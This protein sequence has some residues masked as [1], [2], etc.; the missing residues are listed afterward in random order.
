MLTIKNLINELTVTLQ[1]LYDPRE[2]AAIASWYVCAKLGMERYELA[3]RGNEILD[4]SLM[5]EVRRNMERL[6]EGC[7]VQYVLGE[8][9]FYGL[10]FTVSPAVL[11]PR[12][13]TEELV[14]MVVQRYAGTAPRI[15]DVGTGSGCIAVSLAKSLK[16]A[17]VFATDISSEALTVAR[18]N[19]ERNGVGVTFVCH[20]MFDIENLPFAEEKFDVLV[21]NPPYIPASDRAAMHRNVVD[22]EPA[23][24]LFVPDE[25][26]LWCYKALASLARRVLAP[27]GT[28]WVETYHDYHEEMIDLFARHGFS[29][30]RSLLD[31]NG[32]PR[33]LTAS[34]TIDR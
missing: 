27:G 6:A 31:L 26:K 7:P 5:Q 17:K 34:L 22:Y 28:L 29:D 18:G 1:P 19:A 10:S 32:R 4:E 3:L 2:A 25:D 23:Q 21:S 30:I 8:T 20:D 13:E 16:E 14:Q 11:I 33:F 24:A 9:E 12:P 15:W